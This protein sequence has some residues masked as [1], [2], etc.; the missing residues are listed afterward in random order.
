MQ[1]IIRRQRG[2]SFNLQAATSAPLHLPTNISPFAPHS[3]HLFNP[4]NLLHNSFSQPASSKFASVKLAPTTTTTMK[5]PTLPTPL[6]DDQ[7]EADDGDD[8]ENEDEDEDIE[9]EDIEDQE[10]LNEEQKQVDYINIG[11]AERQV[12][13]YPLSK[14]YYEHDKDST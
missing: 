13:D 4:S 7:S 5:L 12:A 1:E 2:F 14:T 3:T 6:G 10:Y 11:G 8:D 9:D